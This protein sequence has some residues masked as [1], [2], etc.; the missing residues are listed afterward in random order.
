MKPQVWSSRPACVQSL[1]LPARPGPCSFN[2]LHA[3]FA[4]CGL[5]RCRRSGLVLS[6]PHADAFSWKDTSER[7]TGVGGRFFGVFPLN[8]HAGEMQRGW[9]SF[10]PFGRE[11]KCTIYHVQG[12]FN[13]MCSHFRN[14]EPCWVNRMEKADNAHTWH[15]K[16][17]SVKIIQAST[18]AAFHVPS[19]M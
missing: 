9:R 2:A 18:L 16:N 19:K 4:A 17:T 13:A 10:P 6:W 14:L 3:S 7:A 8:K 5:Q 15:L 1:A 11:K 12:D